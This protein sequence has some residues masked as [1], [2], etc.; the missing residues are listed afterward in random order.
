MLQADQFNVF[1]YG[2][3]F[4]IRYKEIHSIYGFLYVLIKSGKDKGTC[5]CYP[6][7]CGSVTLVTNFVLNKTHHIALT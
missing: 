7:F 1:H 5:K 3:I 2:H 6:N 4:F